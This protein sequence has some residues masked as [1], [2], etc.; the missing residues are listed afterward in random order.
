MFN[1]VKKLARESVTAI[2][3]VSEKRAEEAN[4]TVSPVDDAVFQI[5][6]MMSNL[7]LAVLV[8]PA[9]E[10]AKAGGLTPDATANMKAEIAAL[11]AQSVEGY[12]SGLAGHKTADEM[13]KERAQQKYGGDDYVR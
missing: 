2:K 1:T 9:V 4:K 6:T 3:D 13:A 11:Q 12:G 10:A 8:T 7:V 5:T